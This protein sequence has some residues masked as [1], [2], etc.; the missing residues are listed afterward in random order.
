METAVSLTRLS[1][2][3]YLVDRRTGG[4]LEKGQGQILLKFY[5]ASWSESNICMA[6]LERYHELGPGCCDQDNDLGRLS[7][8]ACRT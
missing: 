5:H 1:V 2:K 4:G 8:A 3:T 7:L 6:P